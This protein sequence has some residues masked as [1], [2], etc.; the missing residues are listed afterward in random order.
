MKTNLEKLVEKFENNIYNIIEDLNVAYQLYYKL[1]DSI[2]Y[3]VGRRGYDYTTPTDEEIEKSNNKYAK[4][5][6]S[7]LKVYDK[8][9]KKDV[10]KYITCILSDTSIKKPHIQDI[11]LELKDCFAVHLA[12][13]PCIE[14]LWKDEKGKIRFDSNSCNGK[15]QLLEDLTTEELFIVFTY[16]NNK[17]FD[18][19]IYDV[20]QG[21]IYKKTKWDNLGKILESE[22]KWKE[23][24]IEKM[25]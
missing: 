17:I 4:Y 7:Q 3:F 1:E 14:A 25:R 24:L 5:L 16:I 10:I 18:N 21:K 20:E 19:Y 6:Y 22:K 8:K 9:L 15:N 12:E 23:E 2:I 13:L 11:T